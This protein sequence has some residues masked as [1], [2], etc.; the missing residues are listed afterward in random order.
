MTRTDPPDILGSAVYQDVK[1]NSLSSH[2]KSHHPLKQCD[3]PFISKLENTRKSKKR[4]CRHF[5]NKS[6]DKLRYQTLAMEY[7]HRR[8]ERYAANPEVAW[9]ALGRQQGHRFSSPDLFT[10][11]L[12]SQPLPA[13]LPADVVVTD[14]KRRTRSR[15]ASRVQT[16]LTPVSFDAS[17]PV[18]RRGR[19]SQRAHR[20]AQVRSD[21]SSR[22]ESSYADSRAHPLSDV[23]PIKLQP[24]RTDTSRYSP[25]YAPEDFDEGRSEKPAT[26]PHVRCRVDIKPDESA[27]QH[28]GRK[29]ATPQGD[30]P[31]QKYH[32]G[33]GRSLTVPRHFSSSRTPT[34]TE[35]F[36]G[37]YRQA[38]QYSQSMPNSY[39][40]PME[41]PL[42][43]AV[44]P[45][46]PREHYRR[47]RRAHS[48]PNVPTKFFY[49]EDLGKYGSSAP[50]RTYYQD[51]RYSVPS[52]AYS[53]KIQYVQDPRT[54]IVHAV[55]ARPYYTDVDSYHYPAQPV[56]PKTYA[57][58]EPGAY[59]IQTPPA[60][61]FYGDDPRTYQIQ[62]APPRIFYV[63]DPYAQS[64]E[65]HYPS[66]AYYTEGRRHARAVQPQSDDWYGSEVSGYSSHYPSSYV[67]QV[68]PTRVRQEPKLTTWYANPCMEPER[69][70]TEP[71]PYSRSWDN[72]LD[73]QVEREQPVPRGK[74]DEN[75]LCQGIQTSNER[76]KPVVV[77]LSS[78]PRRYAA[79]SLSENSLLDKSPTEA[80]SSSSKLWFVTPEITITDNDIR[81]SNLSKT[82]TRSASWDVLDPKSAPNQAGP[83]RET[84]SH[85]VESTKDKVHGST[86]LQQSLEQLDEL[87]ADLVVDYKPPARRPSEDLLDQ[88]KK[89]IDEEEAVSSA[90]KDSVA[91]S[92]GS[93][94]LDKQP[95]SIKIDPDALR[96]TDGSCDGLRS[97]EECS[98]DQ[99]PDEDDTMMCSNNRCRRTETLFNACLYFKSCHS[100]YTYYCSRN[101][102]REDW[103]VHKESCLYGRI[104]SVCR[105]V[106]KYCRE[107]AEV[108]KAFSRIAKVGYLSRGRGVLFVGFPNPGSSTNFLQFG[109]E[110]LLMSPTYL[111]LRELESFKDN[112]GDYCKELQEAG[113]E[114]DPNECF[115]L[116]VSI[117]VG[118]QVPDGPSPRVQAPTV[119]KFAKIA[120]ASYSPEKKSQRK[121]SDMETLILTPPPGMADIDKEGEEGRKSREICFIN[122]QRELRIRGVFL[123]HEY[124]HVYQKLCEFVE[125]NRRFTPTTIYPI[126]KR[127]GKQF[128]CMIM[129]ASEP[130]T[131]DWVANPHLLDDII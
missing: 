81:P 72:I 23:H 91:D 130:R 98:P 120:L 44:S 51:D 78:S 118:D 126:D 127:T 113:K 112:L 14:V 67:S 70:A 11:R 96:D 88:L 58:S 57:A 71:R 115:L 18:A 103:D 102:R 107:T 117:A 2:S 90:R 93:M 53:P 43:K 13:E 34:P 104:G 26:S 20:N 95:T 74:S 125:N 64:M 121:E 59:I 63:G 33:G 5:D 109:L 54:H 45:R 46:E 114:Y 60:R 39:M 87:L 31:W 131:L 49:A 42:Q 29:P 35:S 116:N 92:E 22:G 84:K 56:Y 37:E 97:T 3:S 41:I 85:P 101:C 94:P 82:E 4:H 119:R 73:T 1:V 124:P 30:I 129:A 7:P 108:H 9:N 105:H 40:Q 52:Q 10:Y 79:L 80:K 68:T 100:C 122:I 38:Y 36:T 50:S 6:K 12:A 77:N 86:S 66:R 55:S 111:S 69:P 99:S 89:L 24:Q 62:T 17:P 8:A 15:S 110:S 19:E 128:M 32:S 21:V 61:T 106:I 65:H 48:S 83:Q 25:V 47:E 75:L 16:S 76:P 123:R 28:D 27:R